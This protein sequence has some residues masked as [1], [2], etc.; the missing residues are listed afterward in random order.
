MNRKAFIKSCRRKG[1][2]YVEVA[3]FLG[4]SRQRVEQLLHPDKHK[5]RGKVN[6]AGLS[7]EVCEY[8][9][10]KEIET[11]AHHFDYN[12]PLE[13][14]WLCTKHHKEF[15]RKIEV[16]KKI[17]KCFYCGVEVLKYCKYCRECAK[18]RSLKLRRKAYNTNPIQ[19]IRQKKANKNWRENHKEQVKIIQKKAARVYKEKHKEEIRQKLKTR[20]HENIELSRQKQRDYYAK[21]REHKIIK[22]KE[23]YLKNKERISIRRK[24]WYQLKKRQPVDNSI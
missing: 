22:F 3:K 4:V 8:P 13:I 6:K 17:R 14:T 15:H 18:K 5:A 21:N 10:C 23:Y 11:Q 9:G 16:R 7:S 12:R 24:L 2:K 1:Y 20:Y 19:K